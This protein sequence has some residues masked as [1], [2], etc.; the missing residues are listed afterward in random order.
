MGD[1]VGFGVVFVNNNWRLSRFYV[2]VLTCKHV[3][4]S[5]IVPVVFNGSG[6]VPVGR[7]GSI[8]TGADVHDVLADGD[9]LLEVGRYFVGVC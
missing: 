7:A 4:V 2:A 3:V 8:P 5:G 9:L 1:I 6:I